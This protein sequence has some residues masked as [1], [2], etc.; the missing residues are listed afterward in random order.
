MR[1]LLWTSVLLLAAGCGTNSVT[2]GGQDA[3]VP[4]PNCCAEQDAGVPDAGPVTSWYRDVL[5][6]VQTSCQGCHVQGGIAPFALTDY[7][8]AF[9]QRE[10]I[11]SDVVNRKMPPW[12]PD[13]TCIPLQDSR[14]LSEAQ[15]ETV[16]AWVAEGA[17]A[18]DPKDAPP[19]PQQQPGL[20]WVDQTL[21]PDVDYTPNAAVS[22]DYRCFILP[23]AFTQTQ[24]VIGFEALP[25][26]TKEVHHIILAAAPQADAEAA[27]QADPQPGWTCYGGLGIDPAN[28]RMIGG[29]VPGTGVTRY[30]EKTGIRIQPGQV[31][32]MQIHYNLEN[33]AAPDRTR[34]RLQ[35]AKTPVEK[36]ALIFPIS[37]GTF[38][39]PPQSTGHSSTGTFVLPSFIPQATIYGV[40]PHMHE[41]GRSIRVRNATTDQCL[42]NLPTWDFHWQQPYQYQTPVE[43]HGGETI[44]ITCTWDNPTDR[45][46][47]YGEGTSD[48][49][50]VNFFYATTN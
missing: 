36:P 48:E 33:G 23:P 40:T 46:V 9:A 28:V 10:A 11:A 47:T 50:C 17:P 1:N 31:V 16:A 15:V 14:R 32:V 27:D 7:A 18:G 38:S 20:E 45:T 35:F 8:D 19:P 39:I 26:V 49:M 43:V 24:D 5:P 42:I 44:E 4:D 25:G 37:E 2:G 34:V 22:D 3:G 6:I 12:L 30:P 41:L 13:D 21:Q 29:W